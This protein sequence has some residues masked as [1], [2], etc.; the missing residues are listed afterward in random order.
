MSSPRKWLIVVV[1]LAIG[2]GAL[3]WLL[4]RNPTVVSSPSPPAVGSSADTRLTEAASI[5]RGI[6]GKSADASSTALSK[7]SGL[8]SSMDQAESVRWIREFLATGEDRITGLSFVIGADGQLNEWPTLRTFLIDR[9]LA[10]DPEAAA[11]LSREILA[12]P[13][14]SDEWAVCLRNIG[15]AEDG[16]NNQDFLRTKTEELI[17]NPEWMKT[18]SIGYLNAFDVFVHIGADASTPLLS[19]LV[20]RKDRK[21]L[22]HAGFLTLDR[23]VQRKPAE[24]LTRLA[25]DRKIGRAHV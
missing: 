23:L 20:Q 5:L 21:D 18:P 13:T 4:S 1:P 6:D 8:L 10:L 17:R 2:L 25:A 12:S 14:S 16:S 24:M 7:L 3:P 11:T 22:A 15:R 9:M 19:E